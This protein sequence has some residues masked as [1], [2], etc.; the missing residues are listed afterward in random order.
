MMMVFERMNVHKRPD[1]EPWIPVDM[2]MEK[3]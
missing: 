3:V 2:D 1:F